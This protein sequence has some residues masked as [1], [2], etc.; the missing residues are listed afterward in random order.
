MKYGADHVW[1]ADMMGKRGCCVSVRVT[2]RDLVHLFSH[3]MCSENQNI[4]QTNA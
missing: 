2:E 4:V 3:S 1:P